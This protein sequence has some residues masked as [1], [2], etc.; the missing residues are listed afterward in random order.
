ME[1]FGMAGAVRS[2]WQVRVRSGQDGHGKVW[3]VRQGNDR[4]GLA[5]SG[6]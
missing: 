3:Q 5:G 2:G 6:R 4:N 1:R